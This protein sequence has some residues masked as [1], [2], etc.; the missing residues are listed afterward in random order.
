LN[1]QPALILMSLI[2]FKMQ[3][4]KFKIKD[5]FTLIE[6]MVT[7]AIVGVVAVITT[8]FLFSSISGSGKAEIGKEARQNGNYALNVMQRMILNSKSVSCPAGGKQIDVR[9]IN[10]NLTEF[11]C[12]DDPDNEKFKIS[13][14]SADLTG[15]NVAVSGC[16]FSCVTFA[17]K[18]SRVSIEFSVSQKGVSSRPSESGKIDFKTEVMTRNY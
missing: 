6:M 8:G 4:V 2:K 15:D 1:T 16:D 11:F 9:D 7:I 14:N 12:D 17:G 10:D 18:P 5:G 3:N 13:S